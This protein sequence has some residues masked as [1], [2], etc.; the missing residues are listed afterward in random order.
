MKTA[1]E[2]RKA[3]K[4]LFPDE[5]SLLISLSQLLPPNPIVINIGAG[6]GTSGLAFMESR[7]DLILYTI[8]ITN[9]ESPFGSLHS[10]RQEM[11]LA[12]FGDQLG[13]RWIQIHRDSATVGIVWQDHYGSDNQPVDLVFVDGDHSVEGCKADINAWWPLIKPGG[14]M[15]VHDYAKQNIK[16]GPDGFHADGPHP[17]PWP[18][19]D[20]AV[21]DLLM[22]FYVC[23]YLVDSLI[24]FKKEP[25]T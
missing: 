9:E 18:G 8:D 17:Q 12:G 6:A 15:A 2:L 3:F 25:L 10:E 24:V 11:K 21:N 22:P 5:L 23:A 7:P 16:T 19:V 1:S 4:Y 20:K 14:F 13:K